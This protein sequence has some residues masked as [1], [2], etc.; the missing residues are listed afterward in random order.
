[1]PEMGWT[2]EEIYLLADRGYAL[3]RQGRYAEAA[4]IFEALTAL[5]PMNSYCRSA[6]AAVCLALGHAQ[7]AVNELTFLLNRNPADHDARARRCEAYCELRNWNEARQDLA[8]LQRNGE[9]NHA[10][11][12]TWRLQAGG[13]AVQ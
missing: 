8:I 12:L 2:S 10:Q 1:M 7:R 6:L 5:D 13:G 3:Y 11:R 4:V 9:R